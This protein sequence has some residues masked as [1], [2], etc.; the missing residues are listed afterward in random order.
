MPHAPQGC[1]SQDC[2]CDSC[3]CSNASDA[4]HTPLA[5]APAAPSASELLA[6]FT[7]MTPDWLLPIASLQGA[8]LCPP[9]DGHAAPLSRQ[10]DLC[11]WII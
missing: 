5:P 7:P 1:G 2:G 4:T 8:I 3:G 11:V 6:G 10:T 9:A